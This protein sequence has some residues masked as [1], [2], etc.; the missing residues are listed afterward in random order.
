M[1]QRSFLLTC[2]LFAAVVAAVAQDSNWKRYTIGGEDVS[3]T[4]PQLPAI[5]TRNEFV[6]RLHA[7]RV[8]RTF[9]LA[10]ADVFYRITIYENFN[11]RQS[12][13]DFIDEETK[14]KGWDR[15]TER[16]LSVDGFAG[17]E[18]ISQNKHVI[19]QFFA[20]E[21]RLY[22]FE[23]SGATSDNAA[24]KQFFSSIVLGKKG[25]GIDL[26]ERSETFVTPYVIEDV[27]KGKRR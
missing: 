11:S 8:V 4:L 12:L 18:Y 17:K 20:T 24:V 26:L 10:A 5:K 2:V 25:E 27:Y 1:L 15:T 14:N 6:Q 9:E 19:V 23:T 7:E 13:E 21:G 3:V 16:I 22:R